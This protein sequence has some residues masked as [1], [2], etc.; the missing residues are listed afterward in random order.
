VRLQTGWNEVLVKIDNIEGTWAFY[1]E[2]LDPPTGNAL[3]G[4]QYRAT[5]PEKKR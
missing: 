2:L 3:P 5:P 1:L 4:V